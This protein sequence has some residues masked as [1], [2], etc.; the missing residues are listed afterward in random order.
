[1]IF[2]KQ[3]PMRQGGKLKMRNIKAEN[4]KRKELNP[5]R[6]KAWTF[7]DHLRWGKGGTDRMEEFLITYLGKPCVYC[8]I[9]LELSNCSLD[10]K[11]P[12]IRN[13]MKHRA[14]NSH[15]KLSQYTDEEVAFLN[16]IENLQVICKT[17]NMIKSDIPHED[18]IKLMKFLD[19][20]PNL[21]LMV[22]NR[23][24][25]SNLIWRKF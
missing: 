8:G 15:N 9:T 17:C 5:V 4:A 23:M 19:N 22:I 24:R 21:K 2:G 6:Y 11:V 1:M 16:R 13:R 7:T 12:L 3:K 18:F 20:E 10:H 25:R 14:K